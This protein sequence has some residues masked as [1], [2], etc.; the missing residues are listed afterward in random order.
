VQEA[1][2]IARRIWHSQR[3]TKTYP[4]YAAALADCA[5]AAY[6]SDAIVNVV[7]E[8]NKVLK[9]EAAI[10]RT[11]DS[12]AFRTL[13]ALGII[14]GKTKINVIDFGGGGG[15]HYTIAELVH[16]DRLN[17]RWN[18]VETEAMV[19]A[20][21]VM[22]DEKLKFFSDIAPAVAD[23]GTVDLVFSSSALLYCPDPL[24]YLCSLIDIGAKHLFITRTPL[25]E[26]GE[27][28]SI[29]HCNVGDN[30]PGPVPE[31][32]SDTKTSY[33]I[34]FANRRDFEALIETKYTIRLRIKE[35]SNSFFVEGN[36]MHM[37]GY[38][39]DRLI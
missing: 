4:S 26:T 16:G 30:G 18:V 37:Y 34:V 28:V 11:V 3:F 20:A 24:S 33:P 10:H 19:S 5:P 1:K 23:L 29:Q 6:Q 39:C 35:D 32:F 14:G 27:V 25:S 2:Q 21:S 12:S 22:A 13:V 38:A 17:L 31:G 36:P 8:K 7:I 15:Y 9:T